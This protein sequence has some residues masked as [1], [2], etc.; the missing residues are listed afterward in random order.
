MSLATID[1]AAAA[2]GLAGFDAIIDARSPSEYAL[3]HLPGAVNWPVL[4]DAERARVGTLYVQVSALEARKLGAALVARNIA[5]HLE[6][7]VGSLP[8]DWRPLVYCWRGG[9]RSGSLAHVLGQIGFRTQQL[10]G[11]YKAFRGVVRDALLHLPG[12]L[13]FSVVCGRTGSGKTRLLQRLQQHGEQA[14]DLEALARHRGSVL[15]GLPSQPQPGQKHFETLLW[16]ALAGFDA[17]R[18]VW[19]ESESARIGKL[20]VPEAL[21]ERMRHADS[22][23][24]R[25][26][27]ADDARITLL[28]QEYASLQADPEALCALLATLVDMQGR[29]AIGRWQALARA[30]AWRELLGEL[31]QRHYDPLYL[32]S[33][34]R[35]YGSL[36]AA[37]TIDLGDGG[38]QALDAAVAALR[39]LPA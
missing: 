3:D 15:G 34:Q 11:G 10:G 28:L 13:R 23:R 29:E 38:P 36:D 25:V 31:M 18:T 8:R 33:L 24:V 20:R 19:V 4:D 2:A 26:V 5:A 35:S 14:L 1:A 30:G 39:A 32:R 37:A 12:R 21:L 7:H 17:S 16:Q 6:A 27:M 9:Q 22:R